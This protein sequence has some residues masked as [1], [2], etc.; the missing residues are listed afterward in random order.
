LALVV[1]V[2]AAGA[3]AVGLLTVL[4]GPV[5]WRLGGHTLAGLDGRDRADAINSVRQTLLAAAG[6]TAALVGIGFTART[7][8]LS[9]R[10]Q[11][12]DR[13]TK[14]TAQLASDKLTERLGGI[15]AL[16]H[17][18]AE[19]A[20]DHNTVVELLA[21]FIRESAATPAAGATPGQPDPLDTPPAGPGAARTAADVQAALAVLGRRP[22]RAEPNR[23]GLANT[24]LPRAFL[25][26]AQL[27][28]AWL[29]GANLQD[30]DLR[31]ANLRGARLDAANL[32]GA[33]LTGARLVGTH[34]P[35]ARLQS[36]AEEVVRS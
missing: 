19:S 16:E 21:A 8:Y 27:Q 35:D 5:A 15:Y 36:A 29:Q 10:G 1:G 2:V 23:L 28:G 11:F 34:L 18:M 20:R 31:A 13:Y 9:R 30:A 14:A 22:A 26:G 17:P 24:N 6:G 25:G 3:A 7:Y 12:T 32:R 4:L 33:T